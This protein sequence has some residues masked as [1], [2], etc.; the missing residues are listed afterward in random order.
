MEFKVN[1]KAFF[2]SDEGIIKSGYIRHQFVNLSRQGKVCYIMNDFTTTSE[3]F[4]S[5]NE[6]VVFFYQDKKSK[7]L[8]EAIEFAFS[9]EKICTGEEKR[10][11]YRNIAMFLNELKEKK[12]KKINK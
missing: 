7:D 2:I 4:E 9:M 12:I 1:D 11:M 10:V 3:L 5:H 8:D 6:A